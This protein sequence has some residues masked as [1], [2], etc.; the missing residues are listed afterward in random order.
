VPTINF[1]NGTLA[2]G[3]GA[4]I[5]LAAAAPD[6]TVGY[7]SPI[8]GA[9]AHAIVDVFGYFSPSAPLKYRPVAGCRLVDTRFAEQGAPALTANET[10]TFQVQGNCGIPVGAKAAMVNIVSVG[11]TGQG[12][13]LAFA[14]GAAL[15]GGSALNFHPDQGNLANGVVVPLSTSSND[16]AIRAVV[17]GTHVIVDVFGYFQ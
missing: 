8:A 2:L 16:L 15:P 3:N 9:T 11:A 4:R 14:A 17:S 5:R 12:H 7:F 13:L 1:S 6:V 10:R